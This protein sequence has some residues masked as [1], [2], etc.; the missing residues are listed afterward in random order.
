M[1]TAVWN[2]AQDGLA[3]ITRGFTNE[4][5]IENLTTIPCNVRVILEVFIGKAQNWFLFYINPIPNSFHI[6]L[7][8]SLGRFP[9][10]S[11]IFKTN[12]N[13]RFKPLI[14]R[15]RSIRG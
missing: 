14:N 2:A 6:R 1:A 12:M 11:W 5:A 4:L 15:S 10:K 9:I 3:K 13:A 8:Y 7:P